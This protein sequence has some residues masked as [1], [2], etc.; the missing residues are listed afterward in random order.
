MITT[1]I[2]F[3]VSSVYDFLH[4]VLGLFPQMPDSINIVRDL[5]GIEIV[6]QVYGWVNWFLPLDIASTIVGVWC[7]AI[8]AY[9]GIKLAIRYSAQI[10]S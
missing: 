5:F 2:N 9:V 7:T 4:G 1:F 8:M 10:A 3:L 6:A